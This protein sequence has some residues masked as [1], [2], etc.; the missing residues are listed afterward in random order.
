MKNLSLIVV[1]LFV[2]LSSFAAG[3]KA[4]SETA[5]R[6][7]DVSRY[8]GKWYEIGSNPQR[9]SKGC[10]CTRA[11]YSL[12]SAKEVAVLNECRKNSPQA[13]VTKA[14]ATAKF[15]GSPDIG[16]L[17]VSFFPL[18]SGI[19]RIIALDKQNYGWSLVTDDTGKALWILSRS[20]EMNPSLV[21]QLLREARKKGVDTSAFQMQRQD[22]CWE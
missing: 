8:L 12:K 4:P 13:K 11:T 7:F 5:V 15:V 10:N 20:P 1:T 18:T 3:P 17:S 16:E 19:Y 14:N 21:D 2:S 9:F 6:G 22:G